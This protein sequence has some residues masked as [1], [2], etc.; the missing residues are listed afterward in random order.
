MSQNGIVNDVSFPAASDLSSKQYMTVKLNSAGKIALA[1]D[2]DVQIGILQ[3]KPAAANRAGSVRMGG[4]SRAQITGTVAILDRVG[5]SPLTDGVLITTTLD[6][7][8]FVGI[9]LG[10]HTADGAT[11]IID[12]LVQPGI[13]AG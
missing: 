6:T 11:A 8:N 12:V 13:I 9:A 1:E 4:I 5:V 3:D 2:A 10:A 7:V